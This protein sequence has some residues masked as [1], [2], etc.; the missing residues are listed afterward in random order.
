MKP[1]ILISAYK[2]PAI[3]EP[4]YQIP[5]AYADAVRGAGGYPILLPATTDRAEI[6]RWAQYCDGL[7]LPGGEDVDMLLFGVEPHRKVDFVLRERDLFEIALFEEM[8]ALGKPILG[9]CRG[10]QLAATILGGTMYQDIPSER[11]DPLCHK[12][13]SDIRGAYIH[14][15]RLSQGSTLHKLFGEETIYANSF[16]HQAVKSVAGGLQVI[17]EAADGIIEAI[18]SEDGKLLGIQWHPELLVEDH[19]QH[20]R[21]FEHFISLCQGE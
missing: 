1:V 15:V 5:N 4:V 18:E 7:L 8:R 11:V 3:S 12:Q 20:L 6:H 21:I 9:I 17:A 2:S 16:H 13:S 10:M 19:P 14:S